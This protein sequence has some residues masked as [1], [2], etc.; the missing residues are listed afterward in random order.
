MPVGVSAGNGHG[1]GTGTLWR[2]LPDDKADGVGDAMT[3]H[4]LPCLIG[5]FVVRT[6]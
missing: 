2:T 1:I 5:R 3:T 6:S 4:R